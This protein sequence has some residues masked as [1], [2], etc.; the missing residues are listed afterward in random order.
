[1]TRFRLLAAVFLV[2][3]T[4]LI[5]GCNKS[6]RPPLG[7][8]RGTVTLDGKPL[9]G[10][11]VSFSPI[12]GGRVSQDRTDPKGAF[13]LI[14]IGTTRGAKTGK[15]AVRITTA[16]ESADASGQLVEHEEVVPRRYNGKD[17]ELTADI[18]PGSNTVDFDLKSKP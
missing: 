12:D 3:G 2:M 10:A 6:E 17:T 8:V 1:M 5:V 11:I 18:K 14:Y 13:N 4:A 9:D 15:H 16:Y 7:T